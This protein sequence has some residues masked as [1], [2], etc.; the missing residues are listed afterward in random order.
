[1]DIDGWNVS[2]LFEVAEKEFF[3]GCHVGK[4]DYVM[5]VWRSI[6]FGAAA[7]RQNVFVM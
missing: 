1:M 5:L 7:R 3:V 6:G 4:K 2:G